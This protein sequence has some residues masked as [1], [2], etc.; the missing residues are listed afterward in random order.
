MKKIAEFFD[1]WGFVII[2]GIIGVALLFSLVCCI[3]TA[4]ERPFVGI[5]GCGGV[6]LALAVVVGWMCIET[7]DLRE[8]NDKDI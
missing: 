7:K 8:V 3:Y 6:A 4:V 1:K 5:V 2:L